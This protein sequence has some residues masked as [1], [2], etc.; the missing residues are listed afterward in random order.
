MESWYVYVALL[1]I[2]V[3]GA[4]CVKKLTGCMVR[5]AVGAVLIMLLLGAYWWWS[6]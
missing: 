4:W 2:V 6:R 3:A 5:L 1:M